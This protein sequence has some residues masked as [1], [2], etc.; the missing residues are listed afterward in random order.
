MPT[1]DDGPKHFARKLRQKDNDA[2]AALWAELRNRNLN[3]Y[4]FVR[5]LPI[6]KYFADF[7]CRRK[8]LVIEVDGSQHADSEYD[9]V[10][11][12]FL[13]DNGWSV[14]RFNNLLVL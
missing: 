6:G 12:R 14:L 2:E 4:K 5:E 7:A 8:R 3:D 10:R 1:R 11:D 13:N 9:R